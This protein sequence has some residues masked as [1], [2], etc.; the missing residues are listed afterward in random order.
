MFFLLIACQEENEVLNDPQDQALDI[1]SQ[2][3][4]RL[5]DI[6]S[7]LEKYSLTMSSVPGLPIKIESLDP[8][9]TYFISFELTDGEVVMWHDG[10][11]SAPV[12]DYT[13]LQS[14]ALVV[15]W[16]PTLIDESRDLDYELDVIVYGNDLSVALER[17][18]RIIS[19]DEDLYYYLKAESE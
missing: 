6:S 11:V 3:E 12:T 15:Y 1:P 7:E 4:N 13:M 8:S 10:Q 2:P 5:V 19:L 9:Q 18:T 16:R 17:Y 14:E